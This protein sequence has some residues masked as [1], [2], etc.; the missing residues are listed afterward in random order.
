MLLLD[1]GLPRS[2]TIHLRDVGLK[3]DH[4]GEVGLAAAG[5]S[6]ILARARDHAQ[7]VAGWRRP[8]LLGV[9]DF[10]KRRVGAV[11]SFKSAWTREHCG[12][13]CPRQRHARRESLREIADPKVQGS[14]PAGVPG[15]PTESPRFLGAEKFP[16]FLQTTRVPGPIILTVHGPADDP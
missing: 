5:D 3:A 9:C 14:A 7:I 11:G 10:A 15:Q 12:P 4:V 8:L 6:T 13:A 2:T 16:Q 1:Q